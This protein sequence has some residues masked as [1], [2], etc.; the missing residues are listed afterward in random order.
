MRS[1]AGSDG[2]G[3]A[4]RARRQSSRAR[5]WRGRAR[6]QAALAIESNPPERLA[7]DQFY[8]LLAH[9]CGDCHLPLDFPT[10]SNR[11]ADFDN[12]DRMI[13]LGKVSPGN[14]E[15]SR[16]VLRMR[17]G[18]MPPPELP[19]AAPMPEHAIDLIADFIDR[20]APAGTGQP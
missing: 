18:E 12:L 9:H 10:E 16:L 19:E 1:S 13:E 20:L 7:E 14:G 5:T 2:D 15:A 3:R 4:W 11:F 6:E 17:L 8:Q